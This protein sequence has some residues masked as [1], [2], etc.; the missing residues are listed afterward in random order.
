MP[1]PSRSSPQAKK[2]VL[3]PSRRG[4]GNRVPDRS[5]ILRETKRIKCQRGWG[6]G[7]RAR[8]SAAAATAFLCSSSSRPAFLDSGRG[9]STVQR[10]R[11]ST[12]PSLGEDGFSNAGVCTGSTTQT[13]LPEVLYPRHSRTGA[14]SSSCPVLQSR[15]DAE[16][17]HVEALLPEQTLG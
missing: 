9:R 5:I 12:L 11:P 15:L 16:L 6:P 7:H 2:W 14:P 3:P 13:T 8:R 4:R 1:L 17:A 10:P